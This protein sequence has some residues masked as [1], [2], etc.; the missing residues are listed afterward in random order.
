MYKLYVMEGMIIQDIDRFISTRLP[1]DTLKKLNMTHEELKSSIE[2]Q[3]Y[4][5]VKSLDNLTESEMVELHFLMVNTGGFE[6]MVGS[7]NL[8][9]ETKN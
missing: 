9:S 3:P 1:S 8:E 7:N 4:V 5:A 2:K 6:D